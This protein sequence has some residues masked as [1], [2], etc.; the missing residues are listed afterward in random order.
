MDAARSAD[1][2]SISSGT[3]ALP[4]DHV[5]RNHGRT[6]NTVSAVA[7]LQ[8]NPGQLQHLHRIGGASLADLPICPE[9]KSDSIGEVAE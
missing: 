8:Q 6:W 4:I 2:S 9:R 5:L 3:S 7:F 1:M